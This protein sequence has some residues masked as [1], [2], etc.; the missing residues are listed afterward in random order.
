M[1]Y[2]FVILLIIVLIFLSIKP[3]EGFD[4]SN[5]VYKSDESDDSD[6]SDDLLFF[7]LDTDSDR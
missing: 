7:C 2:F 6:D 4:I 3:F 1:K 5:N